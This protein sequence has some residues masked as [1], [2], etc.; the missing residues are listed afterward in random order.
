M[1]WSA[2]AATDSI[3]GEK[4][5][6]EIMKRWLLIAC[7]AFALALGLFASAQAQFGYGIGPGIGYGSGVGIYSS[8]VGLSVGGRGIG[9]SSGSVYSIGRPYRVSYGFYR[10]YGYV[11]LGRSPYGV[12]YS[13]LGPPVFTVPV[14]PRSGARR[15]F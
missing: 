1:V 15:C 12:G 5:G 3:V 7:Q 4:Y 8:G 13:Y 9:F 2:T 11:P 14:V 6:V 10:P